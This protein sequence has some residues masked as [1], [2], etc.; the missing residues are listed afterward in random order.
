VVPA[1]V[2]P[3]SI[4]GA[5]TILYAM[6]YS[7]NILTLLALVLAASGVAW[8]LGT[9]HREALLWAA[10]LSVQ[11]LPYLATVASMLISEVGGRAPVK[12]E[13]RKPVRP[14]ASPAAAAPLPLGLSPSPAARAD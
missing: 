7:V 8:R 1:V 2:I 3:A 6:G 9:D 10:L 4:V 5:F 13:V 14:R 12:T 11:A